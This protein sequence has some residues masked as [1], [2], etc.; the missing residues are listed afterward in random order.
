MTRTIK[1]PATREEW[2]AARKPYIG[3]SEVAIVLGL[4]PWKT[5]VDLWLEKTG[6]REPDD[7]PSEA[8]RLGNELEDYAARR[9]TEQTG[10]AVRNYGYMILD[11]DAHL[12]ADVDRLVVPAGESV[13]AF[14]YEIRTNTILECKTGGAWEDGE[15]P[16]HYQ[17]Q[18]MTYLALSG[19]ERCDFAAVFLAPR[20][21]FRGDLSVE[22]DDD[23]CA[24]IREKVKAWFERHVLGDTAPEAVCEAD[25]KALWA[26]SRG[27]EIAATSM[28]AQAV[29]DLRATADQIRSLEAHEE[30]LRTVIMAHMGEADTL[31]DATGH[32]LATWKSPKPTAKT[33]WK[34]VA[35]ELGAREE[36]AWVQRIVDSHTETKP[37]ARRF[38][39][40][41]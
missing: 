9:Y 30:E 12:C 26:A 3:G 6:H 17:A 4:S 41:K 19:C 14:R 21:D 39:L 5:P 10:L 8:M 11:D 1:K 38:L 20:R 2:L 13:A 27:I 33:D 29:A 23:V 35:A 22:R 36:P 28:V 15:I 40:A 32:K 16:A 34:A 24:A 31:V 37:G 7:T 25:C 18:A